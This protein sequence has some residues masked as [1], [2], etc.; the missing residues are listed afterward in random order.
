[1]WRVIATT[2]YNGGRVKELGPALPSQI[3]D[4]GRPHRGTPSGVPAPFLS[5]V[6][7]VVPFILPM[8]R[9]LSR[10]QATLFR[11]PVE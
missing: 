2:Q 6:P 5:C 11:M 4:K 1:M 8:L 9:D 10:W 3:Q 7:T